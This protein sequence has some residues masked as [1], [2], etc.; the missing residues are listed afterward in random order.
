MKQKCRLARNIH[1]IIWRYI[2]PSNPSLEPK[3]R[4]VK[5][6]YHT[7]VKGTWGHWGNWE[8]CKNGEFAEGYKLRVESK[9]GHGDDSAANSACLICRTSTKCSKQGGYGSWSQAKCPKGCFLSGFRQKVEPF[10]GGTIFAHHDDSAL[11]RIQY[12]CRRLDNWNH[13]CKNKLEA[14]ESSWPN[15]GDWSQWKQCPKGSFICGIKTRVEAPLGGGMSKDDTGLNDIQHKCCRLTGNF[16]FSS[17][18]DP[19]LPCMNH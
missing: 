4:A 19:T 8:Y 9:Q 13:V 10:Q 18:S 5:T 12:E 16:Y 11:N 2:F 15:W 6:I 14:R 7:H 3:W 17:K 1:L